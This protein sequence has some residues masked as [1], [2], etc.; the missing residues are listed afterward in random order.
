MAVTT[1]ARIQHRRGVK[2][3]LPANLNEGELGWCMDT[4]ELFIGNTAA[5]GGNTQIL[6]SSSNLA[7]IAQYT[8]VSDTSVVSVT[9]PSA[10]QPVVRSLQDQI[11]DQWVNVKAYGAQGDGITDDTAAINRAI[12][13]LYTKNLPLTENEKQTR[14]AVWFPS[15]QYLIS[16]PL[17]VY[18]FVRL[19]GENS[20][21]TQIVLTNLLVAQ[22]CVLKLVDS[23]GQEGSSIGNNAAVL[24]QEITLDDL[25][26][27]TTEAIS[28]LL[29]QRCTNLLFRNCTLQ[30]IWQNGDAVVPGSETVGVVVE[31]LGSAITTENINFVDCTFANLVLGAYSTDEVSNL[32]FERCQFVNLFKGIYT[33]NRVAPDPNPNNGPN[34][35]RVSSSLFSYIDDYGIQVMSPNPGVTSVNNTYSNVRAAGVP[36]GVLYWDSVS[37]LCASIGDRFELSS[38]IIN[39]GT[40]NLIVNN[41][42]SNLS[43]GSR[44]RNLRIPTGVSPFTDTVQG[45]D[46]I[47]VVRT[48]TDTVQL[49]LPVGVNGRCLTIKD[50]ENNASANN[51]TV[52]PA[53][54][55]SID[56]GAA[57]APYVINVNNASVSLCY[58]SVL[59]TWHII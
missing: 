26:I 1:I 35:T 7:N 34:L 45:T 33:E 19:V 48:A 32:L 10:A 27:S 53:G 49:D 59:T 23:L 8:F 44:I 38:G 3:D 24:P 25:S 15:G 43:A 5:V 51:I 56:T 52:Q 31:T 42:Q 37:Q 41:N 55:D 6:T 58:D 22:P 29:L 50:G 16:T 11:D 13:D 46:D 21:S 54:S 36:A 28:I 4:R 40:D 57:S 17:L 18:P 9:G 20:A 30:G 39:L 47:I 14:K 12:F 2:S